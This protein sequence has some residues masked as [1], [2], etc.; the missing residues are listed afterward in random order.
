MINFTVLGE[1]TAQGRP[2]A[3]ARGGHAK[4]YD[5]AKSRD[6]KN[7][8]RLVASQHAPPEPLSGPLAVE[9]RVYR[10][11]PKAFS[12]KRVREAESGLI[13][14]VTKPDTDNYI[15]GIKDALN[16][17]IWRDDSSVVEIQA[18]K[19]YSATPRVEVMVR[20]VG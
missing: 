5:P 18:S 1:V 14:P 2:R 19:W 13:R 7:Y 20:G 15:K 17:I 9:I 3:T 4:L 16:G 10:G 8:V 11:M 6:Y 12:K